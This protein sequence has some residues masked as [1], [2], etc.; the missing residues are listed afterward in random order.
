[1][2]RTLAEWIR[3]WDMEATSRLGAA[4]EL[5][6]SAPLFIA[7]LTQSPTVWATTINTALT[8]API[9]RPNM[10]GS[11]S[12]IRLGW[13]LNVAS[14]DTPSRAF[15]VYFGLAGARRSLLIATALTAP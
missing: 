7:S 11:F 6:Y 1:M 5:H 12:A 2:P 10:M 13:R 3:H 8:T 4:A 15:P 14:R 9:T